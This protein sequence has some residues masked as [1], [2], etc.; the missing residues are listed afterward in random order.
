MTSLMMIS[1]RKT[2]GYYMYTHAMLYNLCFHF[3]AFFK[4]LLHMNIPYNCH[5]KQQVTI[6]S[7]KCN[8]REQ[9]ICSHLLSYITVNLSV[10]FCKY[11]YLL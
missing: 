2:E 5:G 10:K 6:K 8:F 7:R 1:L 11:T 4:C 3:V 9:C